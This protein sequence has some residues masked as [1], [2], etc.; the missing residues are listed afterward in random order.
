M[1]RR[2]KATV[3]GSAMIRN[4]AFGGVMWWVIGGCAHA[5]GVHERPA[6]PPVLVG[7]HAHGGGGEPVPAMCFR[8]ALSPNLN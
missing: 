7:V 6:R 3:G 4:P 8:A 1:D 5:G 2:M